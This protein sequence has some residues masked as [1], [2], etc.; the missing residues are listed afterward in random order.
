MKILGWAVMTTVGLMLSGCTTG[1][2]RTSSDS[3]SEGTIPTVWKVDPLVYCNHWEA[4]YDSSYGCGSYGYSKTF[5]IQWCT[6]V[7][8]V[9]ICWIDNLYGSATNHGFAALNETNVV[10]AVADNKDDLALRVDGKSIAVRSA[11]VSG[12]FVTAAEG[13]HTLSLSRIHDLDEVE[14]ISLSFVVLP[15][16]LAT[17]YSQP[18]LQFSS[19]RGC[20][21]TQ[22]AFKAGDDII[23]QFVGAVA[24]DELRGSIDV[25][26]D[27]A[28]SG[29]GAIN[30]T[31]PS[32]SDR[33]M[34]QRQASTYHSMVW[35]PSQIS[36]EFETKIT[37]QGLHTI[38]AVITD[39]R[40]AQVSASA[41]VRIL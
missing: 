28:K 37:N 13:P 38:S 3:S 31:H 11:S 29:S 40:G 4:W 35:S 8:A 23:V 2:S 1:P 21:G 12:E 20:S 17:G 18:S 27:G 15:S 7:K 41:Q 19:C 26:V 6:S 34:P 30:L 25:Q 32:V 39:Q 36:P 22:Q 9:R 10:S 24:V 16:G 14:L 5:G 33:P